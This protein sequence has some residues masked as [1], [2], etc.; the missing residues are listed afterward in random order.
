MFI[1]HED[2]I[3]DTAIENSPYQKSCMS[4]DRSRALLT[5]DAGLREAWRNPGSTK[6]T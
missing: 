6:Q 5:N 4:A 3:T 1:R 2:R